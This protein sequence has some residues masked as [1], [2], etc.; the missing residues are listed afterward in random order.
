MTTLRT[1]K[2]VAGLA[3]LFTLGGVC[4]AAWVAKAD[5]LWPRAPVT[6]V[7]SE[8]WFAQMVQ[9]LELR[10]DQRTQLRPMVE[11]LQREL[12]QLQQE[13]SLRTAEIIRGRGKEMWQVLDADQRVKYRGLPVEQK[14][15]RAATSGSSL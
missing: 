3:V 13:T 6:D 2:I 9:K 10:D 11:Q 4:G 15:P 12:R 8:R 14:L 7:W 5:L 1:W